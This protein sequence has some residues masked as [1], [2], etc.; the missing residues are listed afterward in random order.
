MEGSVKNFIFRASP[1]Q[2][3]NKELTAVS[4][5]NFIFRLQGKR[6]RR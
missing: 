5:K 1:W 4:V 3:L 6:R 2:W